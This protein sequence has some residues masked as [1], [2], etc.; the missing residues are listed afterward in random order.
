MKKLTINV[1]PH[2][3]SPIDT[4]FMMRGVLKAL[5]PAV[6][7]SLIFFRWRAFGVILASVAGCVITEYIIQKTRGAEVKLD[8]LSAVVTGILLAMVL[9]PALPSWMAFLGGIFAVS[10]G[11]EIFGGLG[12]NIFNP[13]LLAR[14]FLMAAFPVALTTWSQPF[15]LDAITTATPLGLAKF[16]HVATSYTSLL[17]GNIGGSLGETSALALLLGLGYLLY[18]RIIDYRIPLAYIGTVAVFATVMYIVAPEKVVQPLFYVLAGGLLIGAA[19][20]ATDPV[21]SPVTAGGRWVFGAGCGLITMTIRLWGGL[22]EGVMYSILLMNAATP[23]INRA[24]RPKRF[25]VIR[26][27]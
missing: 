9:P 18:K 26:G 4:R 20:M 24:T 16:G 6:I 7:A 3:V 11:K 10:L 14:A 13:A 12:H 22:P 8:D 23:L 2:I 1:S 25:G 19:F 15:T 27:K 5:I 21:T 17:V